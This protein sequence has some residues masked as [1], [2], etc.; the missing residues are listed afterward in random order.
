MKFLSVLA[1]AAS[2]SAAALQP[3]DGTWGAWTSTV[4]ETKYSTVYSTSTVTTTSVSTKTVPT[5]IYS[6]VY[7]TATSTK[8]CHFLS[9]LYSTT[10]DDRLSPLQSIPPSTLPLLAPAPSGVTGRY[11]YIVNDLVPRR[12]SLCHS[13]FASTPEHE[14]EG[15]MRFNAIMK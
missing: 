9:R 15:V 13:G 5:T 14:S 2:A 11:L 6:T 10:N 8:V 7:S 12:A 1:L 3:R 4:T